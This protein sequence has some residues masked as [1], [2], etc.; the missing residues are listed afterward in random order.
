M[1]LLEWHEHFQY[2]KPNTS[3]I[4]TLD[5]NRVCE[6]LTKSGRSAYSNPFTTS[7]CVSLCK[8]RHV[9]VLS[10]WNISFLFINDYNRENAPPA[11]SDDTINKLPKLVITS[12]D[13]GKASSIHSSRCFLSSWLMTILS[14]INYKPVLFAKKTMWPKKKCLN[15]LASTFSMKTVLYRGYVWTIPAQFG[16]VSAA[17]QHDTFHYWRMIL[18]PF[19]YSRHS[20]ESSLASSTS[21][22][23]TRSLSSSS[24]LS[25]IPEGLQRLF[26]RRHQ[27]SPE[28]VSSHRWIWRQA[29]P[30][31][32]FHSL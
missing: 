10:R 26:G 23:R 29:T 4:A 13:I 16:N 9:M 18:T 14:Q 2:S 8:V 31:I 15:Y 17:L 24:L 19:F 21:Q 27:S 12:K 32:I 28:N 3:T 22:Y 20:V 11:A 30:W 7:Q 1:Q 6:P 25:M 5:T